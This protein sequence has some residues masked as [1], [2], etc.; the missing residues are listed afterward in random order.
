MRKIYYLEYYFAD[1]FK[2]IQMDVF[3][4]CEYLSSKKKNLRKKV[5]KYHKFAT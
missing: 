4:F 1:N 2:Y 3:M 5:C